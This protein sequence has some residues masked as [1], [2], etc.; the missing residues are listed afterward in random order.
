[1]TDIVLVSVEA[2]QDKGTL[3]VEVLEHPGC[4]L[5][6]ETQV[7][8]AL[9][10]ISTIGTQGAP[11]TAFLPPPDLSDFQSPDFFYFGWN[12]L[13][14]GWLIQRQSIS[15]SLSLSA[16]NG[17]AALSDAWIDRVNLEYT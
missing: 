5:L 16:R 3:Q 9:V 2:K 11:G 17:H 6:V 4:L 8:P 13:G 14:D 1:M 12:D 7:Q 15:T 10:E